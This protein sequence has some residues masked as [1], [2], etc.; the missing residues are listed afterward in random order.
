MQAKQITCDLRLYEIR[1]AR[2]DRVEFALSFSI[3]AGS[4]AIFRQHQSE[5]LQMN[6]LY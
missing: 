4:P 6:K 1:E 2:I 5:S 3:R